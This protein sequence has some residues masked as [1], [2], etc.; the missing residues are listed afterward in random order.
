VSVGDTHHSIMRKMLHYMYTEE[1]PNISQKMLLETLVAADKFMLDGL[2]NIMIQKLCAL[3]DVSSLVS[4][5]EIGEMYEAPKLK[6]ACIQFIINNF[7]AVLESGQFNDMN[8]CFRQELETELKKIPDMQLEE[9]EEPL[10]F[11]LTFEDVKKGG[12]KTTQ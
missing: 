7:P 6:Q 8:T 12:K 1:L 2:K 3:V 10:Q 9:L 11:D 5:L 4:F